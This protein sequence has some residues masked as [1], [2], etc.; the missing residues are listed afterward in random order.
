[1]TGVYT[2]AKR[3]SFSASHQLDY[4]PESHKCSRLH[5]HNYTIEL[6]L[7]ACS[8]NDFDFVVDYGD[9]GPLRSLIAD[10][11]DHRHLNDA[12]PYRPTSENLARWLFE[13]TWELWPSVIA[14]RVSETPETWAEY[15][16]ELFVG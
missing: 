16:R 2:I 13:R 10:E 11:L 4:L 9:L 15:R 8:L 1:M 6:V 7:Q 12:I 5:G 14:V 3:F